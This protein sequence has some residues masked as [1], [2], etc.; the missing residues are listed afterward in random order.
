MVFQILSIVLILSKKILLKTHV[1]LKPDI[2]FAPAR[3]ICDNRR[4]RFCETFQEKKAW[5]K[6]V[7]GWAKN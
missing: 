4:S 1:Y 7:N 5:R 3:G 6:K 2:S